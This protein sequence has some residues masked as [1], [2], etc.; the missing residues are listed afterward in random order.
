MHLQAGQ[1]ITS[2][3]VKYVPV[4]NLVIKFVDAMAY[5]QGIKALKIQGRN[6]LPLHP[7]NWI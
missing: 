6:E 1:F 5:E 3:N 2:Y 4:T 7:F